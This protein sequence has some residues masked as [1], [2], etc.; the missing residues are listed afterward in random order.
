MLRTLNISTQRLTK[1]IKKC[2][3]GS[4][5][6]VDV[7]RVAYPGIEINH[8]NRVLCGVP[9]A[10]TPRRV[11]FATKDLGVISSPMLRSNSDDS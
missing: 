6:P 10:G 9:G 3:K 1:E 4:L 8:C 2:G 7:S 5:A 11:L